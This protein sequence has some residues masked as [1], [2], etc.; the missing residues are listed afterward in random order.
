MLALGSIVVLPAFPLV[1]VQCLLH[2][3]CGTG[4]CSTTRPIWLFLFILSVYWGGRLWLQGILPI[5]SSVGLRRQRSLPGLL[6][7]MTLWGFY[8]IVV[9]KGSSVL[10]ASPC[11]WWWGVWCFLRRCHKGGTLLALRGAAK[12]P[13][14]LQSATILSEISKTSLLSCWWSWSEDMFGA[15]VWCKIV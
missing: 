6:A 13:S 10:V 9:S 12:G 5:G 3:D 2:E 11:I 15:W 4:F 1:R 8:W 14:D 7:C